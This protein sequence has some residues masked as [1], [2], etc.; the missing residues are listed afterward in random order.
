MTDSHT[1]GHEAEQC[2]GFSRRKLLGYGAGTLGLL[3][4]TTLTSTKALAAMVQQE[5]AITATSP[6]F[7]GRMLPNLPPYVNT[8]DTVILQRTIDAMRDV[9]DF[10]HIMDA[11]DV[12]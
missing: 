10:T 7:F 1:G 8:E 3:G 9:G 12:L 5:A 4:A 11:K 2:T 6:Q